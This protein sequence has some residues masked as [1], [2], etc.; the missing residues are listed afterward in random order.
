MISRSLVAGL[1][2]LGC[3]SLAGLSAGQERRP[4]A[5]SDPGQ[6]RNPADLERRISALEKQL[7]RL[8]QEVAAAGKEIKPPLPRQAAE[9]APIKFYLLQHADAAEVAKTLQELLDGDET[10]AVRIAAHPSTN[11]IVM[12]GNPEILE[13]LEAIIKRLEEAAIQTIEAK[14]ERKR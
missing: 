4:E 1:A 14:A 10:K 13:V 7:Q 6:G 8:T 11:N 5:Q 12:R 3:L 9:N 2:L